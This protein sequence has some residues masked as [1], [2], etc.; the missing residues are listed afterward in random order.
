MTSIDAQLDEFE[1]VNQISPAQAALITAVEAIDTKR[2]TKL[3]R[4]GADLNAPLPGGMTVLHMEVINNRPDAV[5]LL[6][7]AG[8]DRGIPDSEGRTAYHHAAIHGDRAVISAL[9]QGACYADLNL[10]DED[11]E[12][13]AHWAAWAGHADVLDLLLIMKA[14]TDLTDHAG[15]TAWRRARMFRQTACIQVLTAHGVSA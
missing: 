4:A 11:G 10:Q 6:I 13:A 3:I 9:L 2:L 1:S 8:A 15:R 7:Q 14:R 5:K 12:T